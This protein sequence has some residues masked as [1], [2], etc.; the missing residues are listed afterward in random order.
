MN[1]SLRI[2]L[3]TLSLLVATSAARADKPFFEYDPK[4]TER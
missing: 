1:T 2:I 4:L 3:I